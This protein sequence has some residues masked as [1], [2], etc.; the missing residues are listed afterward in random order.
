MQGCGENANNVADD[1]ADLY[2]PDSESYKLEGY[3]VSPASYNSTCNAETLN[4]AEFGNYFD[5]EYREVYLFEENIKK[6][7]IWYQINKEKKMLLMQKYTNS[8]HQH[9]ENINNNKYTTNLMVIIFEY[10]TLLFV[11]FFS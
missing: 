7:Y 9:N 4:Y 10:I 2:D 3:K 11:V 1:N 6:S 5:V 8:D